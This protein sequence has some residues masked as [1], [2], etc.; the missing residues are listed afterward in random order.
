MPKKQTCSEKRIAA[1][2]LFLAMGILVVIVSLYV[3]S[4]SRQYQEAATQQST[5]TIIGRRVPRDY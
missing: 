3:A 1:V 5:Y 4:G 2:F